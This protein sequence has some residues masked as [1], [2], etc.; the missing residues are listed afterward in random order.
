[1]KNILLTFICLFTT[2]IAYTQKDTV[3]L[4]NGRELVGKFINDEVYDIEFKH[5]TKKGFETLKI[6]KYRIFSLKDSSGQEKLYY[7]YDT[8]I[9]NYLPENRMRLYVYGERDAVYGFKTP[10]T[11]T[12]GLLVGG[13]S[14]YFMIKDNNFVFIATPLLYTVGN[15][16]FATRV[17]KKSVRN[18]QYIAN[19]DY[20]TGYDRVA[21]AKRV[22]NALKYS[23][24][25]MVLGIIAGLVTN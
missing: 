10:F 25:G 23:L 4:Q 13:A 7:Q 16:F 14:G 17:K 3:L 15:L 21:R 12:T 22:N 19:D 5:L 8:T 6:D 9:G 1:M 11:N 2:L 24:G 20:L 18:L